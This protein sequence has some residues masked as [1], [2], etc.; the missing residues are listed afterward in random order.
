MIWFCNK[1][2]IPAIKNSD[3]S[4]NLQLFHLEIYELIALNV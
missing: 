3:G 2:Y 4:Q 1:N